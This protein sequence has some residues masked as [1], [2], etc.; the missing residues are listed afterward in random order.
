MYI[1]WNNATKLP[2]QL[3]SDL[4]NKYTYIQ[5]AEHKT[6]EQTQ[7]VCLFFS[8][9]AYYLKAQLPNLGQPFID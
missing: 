1:T 3:E 6:E 4:T 8:Q 9:K 5:T 2:K 7:N